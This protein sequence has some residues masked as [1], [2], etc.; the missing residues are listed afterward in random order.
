MSNSVFSVCYWFSVVHSGVHP[1]LRNLKGLGCHLYR[2]GPGWVK[3][4]QSAASEARVKMAP[5][6]PPPDVSTCLSQLLTSAQSVKSG[7]DS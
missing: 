5:P 1:D 6:L 3:Q 7:T 4:K 2:E